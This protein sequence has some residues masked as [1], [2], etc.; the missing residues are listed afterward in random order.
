MKEMLLPTIYINDM[1]DHYKACNDFNEAIQAGAE[2]M[3]ETFSI[4]SKEE[5]I[6]LQMRRTTLSSSL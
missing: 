4:C 1:Y 2:R 5:K 6:D 3:A